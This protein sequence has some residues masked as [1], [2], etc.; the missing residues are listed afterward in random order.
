MTSFVNPNDITLWGLWTHTR[1]VEGFAFPVEPYVPLALFDPVRFNQTQHDDLTKKPSAQ[2]SYQESYSKWLQPILDDPVTFEQ[3]YRYYYQLQ[4]NVDDQMMTVFQALLAS[5]FADNTIVSFT[6][7]HGD[8][9]GS[10]SD[11]HQKW[12]T[13][14]DE[15]IRVPLIVYSRTLFPNPQSV[16]SLTIHVDLLPTLLGLAGID[17]EPIRQQL[18]QDHSDALPLVGAARWRND[19]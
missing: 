10:H 14:Y 2:A 3:Y 6:S 18:A 17:P 15:A 12:Y 5:K 8:L 13:A 1:Q 7:D 16:D 11:M 19:A 9:L 4:K